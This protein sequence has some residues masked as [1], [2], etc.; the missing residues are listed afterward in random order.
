MDDQLE[1]I[2]QYLDNE[3][4]EK[5]RTTFEQTMKA[6]AELAKEVAFQRQFHGF[7][8]RRKPEIET[9]LTALKEEF[10]L[11]PLP[12]KKQQNWMW[13]ILPILLV[14]GIYFLFFYNKTTP[15]DKQEIP[16]T[17]QQEV[18]PNDIEK[19]STKEHT[20]DTLKDETPPT[21]P[22]TPIKKT[23]DNLQLPPNQ[24]IAAIDKTIYKPNPLLEGRLENSV[25][26][27]TAKKKMT[28]V[29]PKSDATLKATPQVNFLV[30][31]TTHITPPYRLIIYSNRTFDIDNDYRI[32]DKELTGTNNEDVF[33]FRFNASLNLNKGL[34]YLIMRKDDTRELLYISRFS[35]K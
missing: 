7:M 31:G 2:I 29:Y 13:I 34:Y 15:I 4:S 9:Q 5:E 14:G 8:S 24:P 30:E 26:N 32:L 6:D 10:K 27:S 18:I 23:D 19:D 35:V 22:K 11:Q 28:M 3:M 16:P 1:H 33:S 25:R 20:I 17:Q 12:K 21:I